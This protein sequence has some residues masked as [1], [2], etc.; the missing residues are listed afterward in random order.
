M[1][2]KPSHPPSGRHLVLAP[3]LAAL[4]LAPLLAALVL[5]P[6]LADLVLAGVL[7][8]AGVLETLVP[9]ELV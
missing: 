1:R 4:V 5:A 2:L 8:L 6:L 7:D 3:F 9:A